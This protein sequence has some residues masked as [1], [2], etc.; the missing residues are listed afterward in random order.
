MKKTGIELLDDPARFLALYQSAP[1][2]WYDGS[3]KVTAITY[4]C[5]GEECVVRI[6]CN[7]KDF[8]KNVRCNDNI[9]KHR[10][11]Y[12]MRI[13]DICYFEVY[14]D[15]MWRNTPQAARNKLSFDEYT[16]V[17]LRLDDGVDIETLHYHLT[18]MLLTS[19]RKA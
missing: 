14:F 12:T 8:K 17:F 18:M 19:D 2:G 3:K 7:K 15:G 1:E 16:D 13:D 10:I 11:Y 5:D 4:Q 9:F 6:E